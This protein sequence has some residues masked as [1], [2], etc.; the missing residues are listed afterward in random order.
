MDK[1]KVKIQKSPIPIIWLDTSVINYIAKWKLK[2]GNPPEQIIVDRVSKLYE[3]IYKYTREGKVICPHSNQSDEI[4]RDRNVWMGVMNELSMD[5][6]TNDSKSI[7]DDQFKKFLKAFINKENYIQ[8]KY[9]EAF[10]RNPIQ[11]LIEK[12]SASI[13]VTV[14][15]GILGGVDYHKKQKDKLLEDLK[16]LRE[17]IIKQ[18]ISFE[19]QLENE[20]HGEFEV[21]LSLVSEYTSNTSRTSEEHFNVFWEYYNVSEQLR[22]LEKFTQTPPSLEK[23]RAYY[24]SPYYRA[25]PY[26]HLSCNLMAYILTKPDPIKPGDSMDIKHIATLMPYS[27]LFI[28]DRSMKHI[29]TYRKFDK[30]YDTT[31]CYIG[32]TEIINEFFSN[33]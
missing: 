3:Q 10:L 28:T 32:D 4:W 15:A 2:I 22:W 31:V 20:F 7:H 11:E 6:R 14:D 18:G 9:T 5:I 29:I 33:L 27:D 21:L 17:R 13:F 1:I 19:E 24:N 26:T 8:L 30:L 12:L 16:K 25:M 23:L